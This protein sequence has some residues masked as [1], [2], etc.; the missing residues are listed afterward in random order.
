MLPVR[1]DN[2]RSVR[3][4]LKLTTKIENNLVFQSF[5]YC[6]E[7]LRLLYSVFNIF[8]KLF[9]SETRDRSKILQTAK[10]P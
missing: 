5:Y 7:L 8:Q 9:V 4:V 1:Q 10:N 3:F 2:L 6:C